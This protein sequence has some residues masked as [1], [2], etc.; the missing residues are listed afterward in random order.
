MRIADLPVVVLSRFADCQAML[1]EPQTSVERDNAD[2]FRQHEQ[3]M[4]ALLTDDGVEPQ[5]SFLFLDPPDHTRLRRLVSKAFTPRVVQTLDTRIRVL[6]DDL[7]DAAAERGSGTIDLIADL[8]YPLP[9]AVICQLL[10]VPIEDESTFARWSSLLA[11]SLDPVL[12]FSGAADPQLAEQTNA[13]LAVRR[14]MQDLIERRRSEPADDLL[15]ALIAAEESG[16]VLTEEELLSTCVLLLV[17]G[18]ETTVNLIGNGTLALLRNPRWMSALA[19]DPELGGA[20]VEEALR[21]DPPVQV[22]T[23]IPGAEMRFGD[24]LLRRGDLAVLMLGAAHRDPD[25]Y[26][27]PDVFDPTRPDLRHLAFSM[28]PHF[29]V[30]APLARLEGRLAMTRL[31]G[32]VQGMRL[33]ADPPPYKENLTLRGL[34]ALPV[35][36]TGTADRTTAW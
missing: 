10:G 28:G 33:A 7:L 35:E 32:R 34:A 25:A 11:R 30:G 14:Y 26:P 36:F 20:I 31:A 3:T 12:A 2:L 23:R 29:C 6:V 4:A 9:V 18:H 1:R 21:Y 24:V 19:S 22:V 27:R 8:A 17:A 16:D 15:S 5:P 13:M